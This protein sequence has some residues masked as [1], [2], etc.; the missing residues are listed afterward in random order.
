VKWGEALAAAAI[1]GILVLVVNDDSEFDWLTDLHGKEAQ[2][3]CLME[4]HG[5]AGLLHVDTD[6]TRWKTATKCACSRANGIHGMRKGCIGVLLAC[7][8]TIGM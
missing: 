1:V 5:E 2:R 7:V 3:C 4:L 6:G 8:L